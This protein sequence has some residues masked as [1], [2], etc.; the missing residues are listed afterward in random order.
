MTNATDATLGGLHRPLRV[1]VRDELRER[2]ATGDLA[3][4]ARLIER[5]LATQLGV[6]RVPVREAIRM[7]EAEG[8]VR[9][10][11]RKGVVV[12]TL[13]RR[14]VEEL[15]DVRAAL[16]VMG[17]R[18]AAERG[19]AKGFRELEGLLGQARKAID[20]GDPIR[21]ARANAAFHEQITSLSDNRALAAVMEPLRSRMRWLFAQT[22]DPGHTV[23]E[24]EQ[25]FAAIVSRDAEAA[26]AAAVEHVEMNRRHV[27]AMLFE[28]PE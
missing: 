3:P 4:G 19:T 23:E 26:A 16:E 5:D 17:C 2:I 15:F 25:L 12:E 9:T 7:L 14:D 20:A 18:L 28:A 27:L 11:P 6:S 1:Q 10:V 8:L 21:I 22:D 13:S 24:H